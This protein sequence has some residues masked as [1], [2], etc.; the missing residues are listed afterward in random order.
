MTPWFIRPAAITDLEAIMVIESSQ[1]PEPWTPTMLRDELLDLRTRRYTV[2]TQGPLVVGYLGLMYVLHDEMHINTIGTHRDYEGRGIA[3]AL[4]NDGWADARARGVERATL[5]V[6][7]SNTR[8]QSLYHRYGFAPVGIRKN[9]YQTIDEDALVMWAT[10]SE[11]S[12]P[13]DS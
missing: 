11:P 7:V 8:A 2:V 10:I 1:F 9:Y 6:A 5:E 4:L 12:A 3:T 13:A